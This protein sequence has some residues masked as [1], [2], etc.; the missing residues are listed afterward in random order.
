MKE[1]HWD[2]A[3]ENIRWLAENCRGTVGVGF[4]VTPDNFTEIPAATLL[5]YQAGVDNIRIG[6][7]FSKEGRKFYEGVDLSRILEYVEYAKNFNTDDFKVMDLFGRRFGDLEGGSPEHEFC[8][9]QY[10]TTYIGADLNV[11]RCCNTAYTEKGMLGSLKDTRLRDFVPQITPFD[12]RKCTFCQFQGQNEV[13]NSVL[14]A[15]KHES[16]V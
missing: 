13:I 4:V 5:A 7:V 9:Y 14:Q 1:S 2:K 10:F 3:W 6:A 8:G 15:P 12:A 16:F 11:Y